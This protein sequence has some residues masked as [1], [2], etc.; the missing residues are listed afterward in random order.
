MKE[1]EKRQNEPIMKEIMNHQFRF[2]ECQRKTKMKHFIYQLIRISSFDL[3]FENKNEFK[4]K[5]YFYLT[6]IN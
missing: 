5:Y 3:H 2:N 6:L 4:I 1:E